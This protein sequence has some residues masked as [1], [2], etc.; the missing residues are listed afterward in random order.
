MNLLKKINCSTQN[1]PE[2]LLKF[3]VV[4]FDFENNKILMI[5]INMKIRG[6]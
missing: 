2:L 3:A 1:I 5:K 4:Q 6:E